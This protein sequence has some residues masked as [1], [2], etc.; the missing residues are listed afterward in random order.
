MKGFY[1]NGLR[2]GYF[3]VERKYHDQ[4]ITYQGEYKN[5]KENPYSVSM[6]S[7]V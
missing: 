7:R 1:K 4:V 2:H 5:D 3:S 6:S